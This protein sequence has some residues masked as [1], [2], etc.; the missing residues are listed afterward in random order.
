[1][2]TLRFASMLLITVM[3]AFGMSGCSSD[4]D[5]EEPLPDDGWGQVDDEEDG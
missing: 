3:L 1:M 4:D 2:K 5:E